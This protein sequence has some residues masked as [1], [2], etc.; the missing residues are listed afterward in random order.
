MINNTILS[1]ID[2]KLMVENEIKSTDICSVFGCSRVKAS[3]VFQVYLTQRPSN[4]KYIASKKCYVKGFVFEADFLG[5]R[6][7]R[8]FLD[9]ID[10]I[11]I[12]K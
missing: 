2:A 3:R 8:L 7:P 9:A 1:F 10:L 12:E 6:N 11:F 5:N 4:M